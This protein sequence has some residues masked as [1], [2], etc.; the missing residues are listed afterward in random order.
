MG[1]RLA[2][3]PARVPTSG[4]SRRRES[5]GGA[6]QGANTRADQLSVA[7]T[8]GAHPSSQSCTP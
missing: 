5:D 3:G 4:G 8:A 1:R 6:K 2:I 7:S